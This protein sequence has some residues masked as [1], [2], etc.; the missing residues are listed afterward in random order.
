MYI[1]QIKDY[2]NQLY[3][4][5]YIEDIGEFIIWD[6]SDYFGEIYISKSDM[7][8]YFKEEQIFIVKDD[9]NIFKD[10]LNK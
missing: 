6:C 7:E 5:T 10:V 8:K 2:E 1:S 4:V 3:D 9:Y